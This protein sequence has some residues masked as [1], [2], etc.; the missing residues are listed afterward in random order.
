MQTISTNDLN[1]KLENNENIHLIDVLQPDAFREGHLPGAENVPIGMD[2]EERIQQAVPDKS[3]EVVLYCAST[4]C[5]ASEKAYQ[6]MERLGYEN[7][8]DYEEGKAGW[9]EAGHALKS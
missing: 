2:F 5:P 7:I 3:E 6:K 1:K 8:Y 4:D 9:K